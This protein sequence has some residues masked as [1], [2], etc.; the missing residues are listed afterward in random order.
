MINRCVPGIYRTYCHLTLTMRMEM[1]MGMGT[2]E[3]EKLGMPKVIPANLYNIYSLLIVL[4]QKI[5]LSDIERVATNLRRE[6]STKC[7]MLT[8]TRCKVRWYIYMYT[9]VYMFM[10]TGS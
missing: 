10:Y 8:I 2:W 4:I 3:W 6:F 5:H 9:Q 7:L 1:G